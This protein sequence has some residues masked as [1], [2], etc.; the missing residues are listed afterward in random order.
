MLRNLRREIKNLANPEKA[1]LL[2]R[3][4]KTGKGEYGEGE[5]FVGLMVPQSRVL[6]KK[7]R[8]LSL[9]ETAELLKSKVHE[10]RLI[11]LFILVQKFSK[12]PEAERKKIADFYLKHLKHVNNWDLVDLSAPNILGAYLMDK[13]RSLLTEL[14]QSKNLW[15][16]RV[17]VLSTFY[18]IRYEKSSEW[19]FRI[20][21]ML[22][23][24][25]HDLIHKATGW[26]LREVGKYISQKEEEIFL[27]KHYRTMPRTMLRYAIEHFEPS[28]KKKY[29]AK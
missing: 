17:A 22:L 18:F 12:A 4:F 10:E 20:A 13:D 16:R 27:K 28:L 25:K 8:E 1:K 19:S 23:N 5:V 15:S 11:A 26:M 29:M 2:A 3:Y 14:A 7:Y 9:K 21:E 24:D 6:A